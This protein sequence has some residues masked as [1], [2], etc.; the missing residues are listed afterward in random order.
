VI[1]SAHAEQYEREAGVRRTLYHPAIVPVHGCT[2]FDD[3]NGVAIFTPLMQASVQQ[4][5][6]DER[7]RKCRPQYAL[8]RKHIV[9]LGTPS[10]LMFMQAHNCIHGSLKPTNI[11][12]DVSYEPQVTGCRGLSSLEPRVSRRSPSL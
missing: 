5:I 8:T 6:D 9:L 12:L 2:R 3:P 4:D 1:D 7:S 10:A 11:V